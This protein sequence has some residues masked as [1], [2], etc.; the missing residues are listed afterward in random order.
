MGA[1]RHVILIRPPTQMGRLHAIVSAQHPINI[2]YVA[3][4]LRAAGYEPVLLDY[5]VQPWDPEGLL[6]EVERLDPLFV[7]VSCMTPLIVAGSEIC[8]VVKEAFPQVPTVVAGAHPTALPKKTLEDFPHFDIALFGEGEFTAV[9]LCRRLEEGCDLSGLLGVAF[10][11]PAGRRGSGGEIVVNG[12]RPLHKDLDTIPLPAR[13]ML[14][15][16][17]YPGASK[18]GLSAGV[19]RSTQVF[20]SRGCPFLCTF[21][22]IP[23][24]HNHKVRFRSAESV[25][26]ELSECR[27]KWGF[28][29]VTLHDDTFTVSERRVAEISRAVGE[30]GVSWD[31]DTRV[32]TVTREML[33]SMARHGCVRVAFGVEAGSERILKLIKKDVT[34]DQI[35]NAFAWAREAGLQTSGYFIVGSH[36]DETPEEV[37]MTRKLIHEIAPDFAHIAVGVPYP[38]TEMEREM[39]KEGLIFDRSWER[40]M[41][42]DTLPGWR[43]RHYTAEQLV[44]EQKRLIKDYFYRPAYIWGRFKK[45]GFKLARARSAGD[46]AACAREYAYWAKSAWIGYAFVSQS[47]KGKMRLAPVSHQKKEKAR[48]IPGAAAL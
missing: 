30:S 9:E 19:N 47:T 48:A 33:F 16:E 37:E 38:G 12:E 5:E 24:A 18:S 31:C 3:S 10:R 34:I 6:A 25:R 43:T 20:T 28:P 11:P 22:A 46:L 42:H 15:M 27:T 13:D 17:L 35:R 36:P 14:R 21:C 4:S 45:A 32:D 39:L 23:I 26:R 41:E 2:L 40:Y 1:R 29:H 7:G 8:G 44:R